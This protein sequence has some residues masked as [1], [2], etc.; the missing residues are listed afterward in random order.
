MAVG[1]KR[2]AERSTP[3]AGCDGPDSSSTPTGATTPVKVKYLKKN[4]L[5][6]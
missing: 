2:P 6:G 1:L 5:Y 4:R 3:A